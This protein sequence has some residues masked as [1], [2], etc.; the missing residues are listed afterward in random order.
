MR[1]PQPNENHAQSTACI[2]AGDGSVAVQPWD[3]QQSIVNANANHYTHTNHHAQADDAGATQTPED[4][5]Q[6][7]EAYLQ[8]GNSSCSRTNRFRLVVGGPGIRSA[9]TRRRKSQENLLLCPVCGV[10][11]TSR[12]NYEGQH[13]PAR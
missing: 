1:N 11:I 6:N 12:P 3:E 7:A 13:S 9:S 8:R 4:T 2:S 5:H 10:T